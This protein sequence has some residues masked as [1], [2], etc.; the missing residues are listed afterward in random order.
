MDNGTS[1]LLIISEYQC[2]YTSVLSCGIFACMYEFYLWN[3]EGKKGMGDYKGVVGEKAR[4]LLLPGLIG[5]LV[6]S[7]WAQYWHVHEALWL[8]LGGF[9]GLAESIGLGDE[10]EGQGE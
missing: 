6:T 9:G 4:G 2:A 7:P 5:K 10:V 3:G 8:I 1:T